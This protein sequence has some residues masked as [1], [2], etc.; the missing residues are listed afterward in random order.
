[1]RATLFHTHPK[2]FLGSGAPRACWFSSNELS[3]ALLKQHAS[4]RKAAFSESLCPPE[5]GPPFMTI[6][7]VEAQLRPGPQCL[8]TCTCLLISGQ[9]VFNR[10]RSDPNSPQIP[11]SRMNEVAANKTRDRSFLPDEPSPESRAE[12]GCSTLGCPMQPRQR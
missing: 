12:V 6:T 8:L 4:V 7:S 10:A 2:A 11:R 9:S 1:M 3:D 5:P